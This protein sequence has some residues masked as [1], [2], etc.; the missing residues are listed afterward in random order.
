MGYKTIGV[1]ATIH[2]FLNAE[3]IPDD[4]WV[5]WQIIRDSTPTQILGKLYYKLPFLLFLPPSQT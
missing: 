1:Q 5:I 4:I 3:A 2:R